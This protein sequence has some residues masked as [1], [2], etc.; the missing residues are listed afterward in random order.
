MKS[1][2]GQGPQIIHKTMETGDVRSID[3]SDENFLPDA[4]AIIPELIKRPVGGWSLVISSWHGKAVGMFFTILWHGRP[5]SWN[6]IRPQGKN[7]LLDTRACAESVGTSPSVLSA[8]AD[9]EQCA[10]IALLRPYLTLD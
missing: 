7:I 9:L 5:M 3:I 8:A 4:L 6:H 2:T 10:A 1:S